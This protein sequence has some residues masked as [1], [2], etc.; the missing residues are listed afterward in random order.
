MRA[1]TEFEI[2]ERPTETSRDRGH[3]PSGPIY[4]A[5]LEQLRLEDQR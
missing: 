3:V 4:L 1:E 2:V 5:R